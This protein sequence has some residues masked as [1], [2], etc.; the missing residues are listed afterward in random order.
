MG[1]D[2]VEEAANETGGH[3]VDAY[4]ELRPDWQPTPTDIEICNQ[5][6][7]ELTAARTVIA[8]LRTENARLVEGARDQQTALAMRIGRGCPM[9]SRPR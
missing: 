3:W 7:R 9:S 4:Q 1:A 5:R 2:A 8:R 6:A